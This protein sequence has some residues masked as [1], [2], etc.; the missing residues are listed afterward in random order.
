MNYYIFPRY[1]V[2]FLISSS[3]YNNPAIPVG[4]PA[5]QLCCFYSTLVVPTHL[6]AKSRLLIAEI[7]V[8]VDCIQSTWFWLSDLTFVAQ[9]SFFF[10]WNQH[11]CWWSYLISM[12]STSK[13]HFAGQSLLLFLKPLSLLV[14]S[15]SLFG[16]H[17][18]TNLGEPLVLR[19]NMRKTKLNHQMSH[20]LILFIGKSHF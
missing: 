7:L 13:H 14:R 15:F 20:S 19:K 18:Q 5:T 16:Q 17:L 11:F 4:R 6:L 9:I 10:L 8:F 12:C 3:V 2:S 1:I